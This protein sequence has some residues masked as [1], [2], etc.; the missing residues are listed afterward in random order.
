MAVP[1]GHGSAASHGPAT[2]TTVMTAMPP[3]RIRT[4]RRTGQ[5]Q[6]G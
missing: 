1:T 6:A 2:A 4:G 5:D 3:W